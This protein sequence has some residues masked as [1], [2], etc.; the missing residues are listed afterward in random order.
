MP[1][2]FT[3]VAEPGTIPVWVQPTG[4]QDAYNTGDKV[5]YPTADDPVYVSTCDAN[6][7]APDVYGW[8][9]DNGE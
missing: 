2:L 9:L 5:H 1:A 4:A 6:V 7:W 3:N 8:E